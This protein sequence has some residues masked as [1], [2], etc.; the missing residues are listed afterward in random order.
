MMERT[1]VMHMS[2]LERKIVKVLW[3]VAFGAALAAFSVG[4]LT[5]ANT[6]A[7]AEPIIHCLMPHASA[8]DISTLHVLSRKLGHFLIPAAAYLA[9]VLGPLRN[10]RFFALIMC[11][12]FA[13]LDETLQTLTP[14]RNGS[15]FDVA[16]DISGA[17][18]SF[19]MCS[20]NLKRTTAESCAE[21]CEAMA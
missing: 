4:F 15:L 9:L 5:H 1:G 13:V 21:P 19:F 11:A 18:F 14:G 7:L 20:Q 2:S 6:F 3:T 10:H 16:L 8:D 17:L 12:G